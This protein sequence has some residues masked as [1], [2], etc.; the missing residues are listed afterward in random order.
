MQ[1]KAD[2]E[3]EKLE[4]VCNNIGWVVDSF[5]EHDLNSEEILLEAVVRFTIK[6]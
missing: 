6:K 4:K 1:D 5:D 2:K 3:R